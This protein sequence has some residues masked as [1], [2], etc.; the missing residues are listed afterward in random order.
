MEKNNISQ[1]EA[2]ASKKVKGA[3][4]SKTPAI[5]VTLSRARRM[6][7]H[8]L[9]ATQNNS[10]KI[11]CIKEV[12]NV[13]Y[14]HDPYMVWYDLVNESKRLTNLIDFNNYCHKLQRNP[15]YVAQNVTFEGSS[16][17]N[18]VM[19]YGVE[20]VLG[21]RIL[22]YDEPLFNPVKIRGLLDEA[23]PTAPKTVTEP[24]SARV[25]TP[26]ALLES[27]IMEGQPEVAVIMDD[28][29]VAEEQVA[30]VSETAA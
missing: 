9:K 15:D 3:K 13:V 5:W 11:A 4:V 18:K 30:S 14:K 25:E 27:S 1:M 7:H 19:R 24:T 10:T 23:K 28:T 17:V 2:Q 26:A 21:E 29:P 22:A 12:A 16:V 6:F 20:T 8:Q